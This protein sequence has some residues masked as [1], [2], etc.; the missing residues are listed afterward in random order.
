VKGLLKSAKD[1]NVGGIAIA[2]SKMAAVSG[3]GITASLELADSKHIFDESQS[4][5][6]LEVSSENLTAVVH[7]ATSLGLYVTNIGNVGGDKVKVNDVELSLDK[8]KDIYF[9]TFAR[10]IEQ[11]L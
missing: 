11:D 10:T 5:A 2:L 8:V 6:L 4:R 7:M 3:K 1:V 9:N